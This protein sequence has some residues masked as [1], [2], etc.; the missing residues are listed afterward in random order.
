MIKQLIIFSI[1]FAFTLSCSL[2]KK[3]GIKSQDTLFFQNDSILLYGTKEEYLKLIDN[4]DS[5]NFSIVTFKKTCDTSNDYFKDY[6]SKCQNWELDELKLKKIFKN[7]SPID[8]SEWNNFY[9]YAPCEYDGKLKM[10]NK[11]FNYIVEAGSLVHVKFI[12]TTFTFGYKKSDKTLFI[13]SPTYGKM[14]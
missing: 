13:N 12:D 10:G 11:L 14:K 8:G 3:E 4:F 7:I 1:S 2:Q 5:S 6:A 9:D